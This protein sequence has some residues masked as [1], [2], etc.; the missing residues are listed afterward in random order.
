MD[1]ITNLK[2]MTMDFI[3]DVIQ[4]EDRDLLLLFVISA[5]AVLHMRS[6]GLCLPFKSNANKVKAADSAARR[7]LATGRQQFWQGGARGGII[8]ARAALKEMREGSLAPNQSIFNDIIDPIIQGDKSNCM[9]PV[10]EVVAG[11]QELGVNPDRSICS[12]LL[13]RLDEKSSSTDVEKAM[14]LTIIMDE[15][16]DAELLSLVVETGVRIGKPGL[17]APKLRLLED[18]YS[19][20]ATDSS[21]FG[22]LIRYH[23]YANDLEGAWRCWERMRALDIRPTSIAVGCMVEALVSN[24]Q[25]DDGYELIQMLMEDKKCRDLVNSVVYCSVIK[26]YAHAGRMERVWKVWEE[27]LAHNIELSVVTLNAMIDACARN[28]A[29]EAVPDLILEMQNRG[30]APN[31]VTYTTMIKCF[32]QRGD[33]PAALGI[34]QEMRCAGFQPDEVTYNTLMNGCAHGLHAD[35]G[36][37]LLGEMERDGVAPSNFTLSVLVKLMSKCGKLDRAFELVDQICTRYSFKTN[38]HVNTNLVHAC[39]VNHAFRRGLALYKR[40]QRDHQRVE[41]RTYQI[42]MRGGITAGA[43]TE[44]ISVLRD[45]LKLDM[46]K[47]SGCRRGGDSVLHDNSIIE[48][49][50]ALASEHL[51]KEVA[52]QL[53]LLLNDIK[54]QRARFYIDVATE[55][56]I[57]T[58]SR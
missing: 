8:Q 28:S 6:F 54:R 34:V 1:F 7:D 45:A 2:N 3:T 37:R 18:R 46:E 57:R 51:S 16:V 10:W 25:V 49:V 48:V 32:C 44:V 30:I 5:V 11:M 56:R 36:E 38:S 35:E 47:G 50:T 42:L 40:L 20:A 19:A 13:R 33:L 53:Q 17:L 58:L 41:L 4:Q 23:G 14:R 9:A 43:H 12:K 21:T 29:V 55:Q 27:L 31:L 39:V 15:P 22:M 26:G 24:D 52:K